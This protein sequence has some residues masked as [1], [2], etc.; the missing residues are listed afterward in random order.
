MRDLHLTVDAVQRNCHVADARHAR[1]AALCTYLLAMREQFRW[2]HELPLAAPPSR[3]ELGRWMTEREALWE[4]LESSDFASV[5]VA[6]KRHDPFDAAT[7]NRTLVPEGLVYGAGLGRLGRPHFFLGQLERAESRD[8]LTVLVSGCEYARDIVSLPGALQ[9]DTVY[10]RRDALRRLLWD[11]IELWESR[12]YSGPLASALEHF[13][14]RDDRDAALEQML[15]AALETVI[16]HELGERAATERLGPGWDAMLA[17]LR[18]VRAEALAR[19][20]RDNL[21]DC[22]STLPVLADRASPGPIDLYAAMFEGLRREL[23]PRLVAAHAAADL[24][25]LRAASEAGA[26]HWTRAGRLVLDAFGSAA[27]GESALERL[28]GGERTA[29]KL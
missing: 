11:R 8:G 7:I 6:G 10:I 21:A 15:D 14:W 19:A 3:A 20:V 27:G 2:E 29:L 22:L 25:A 24:G 28:L 12:R 17:Q 13:G 4:D 9:G 23:F 16:L 1:D 26:G 5:P 18:G